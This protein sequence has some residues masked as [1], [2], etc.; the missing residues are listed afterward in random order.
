[1]WVLGFTFA[2]YTC[3]FIVLW[4]WKIGTM[5]YTWT[6]THWSSLSLSHTHL[7]TAV[8]EV[9]KCLVRSKSNSVYCE[10]NPVR[11]Q[12][13]QRP[14]GVTVLWFLSRVITTDR[15][16]ST[17]REGLQP[18]HTSPQKE[19]RHWVRFS[20]LVDLPG[21]SW[22]DWWTTSLTIIL[23]IC[24]AISSCAWMEKSHSTDNDSFHC[25]LEG[26]TPRM[27]TLFCLFHNH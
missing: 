14:Q 22:F 21:L 5:M 6:I 20:T 23:A 9:I 3:T 4:S 13:G 7:H 27:K 25:R 11:D 18:R 24:H 17:L 16:Q 2:D 12:L 1:M 8:G 15:Q 19:T 26:E 10:V